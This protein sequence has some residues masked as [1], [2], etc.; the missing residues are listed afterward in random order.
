MYIYVPSLG[1][2]RTESLHLL[3]SV[4]IFIIDMANNGI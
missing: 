3:L 2:V 1:D 4:Y